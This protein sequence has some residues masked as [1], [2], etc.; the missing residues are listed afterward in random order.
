M[1]VM[2]GG[3]AGPSP[4][5]FLFID[6]IHPPP[7]SPSVVSVLSLLQFETMLSSCGS[8]DAEGAGFNMKKVSGLWFLFLA[9]RYFWGY[10]SA[11]CFS[12]H[13]KF[14]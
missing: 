8:L 3:D 4:V 12:P 2:D 6:L 14:G 7:S 9:K 13:L 10:I 5:F 1:D 11:F